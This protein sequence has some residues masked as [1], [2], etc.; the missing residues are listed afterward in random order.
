M[1]Y[2]KLDLSK[3]IPIDKSLFFK[4]TTFRKCKI[5]LKVWYPPTP[6]KNPLQLLEG[7]FLCENFLY[8]PST[9]LI[10]F[11]N[12][13]F[14]DGTTS[15]Q[16]LLPPCLPWRPDHLE[17]ISSHTPATP[18]PQKNPPPTKIDNKNPYFYLHFS[19]FHSIMRKALSFSLTPQNIFVKLALLCI[20]F[21]TVTGE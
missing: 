10:F 20:K 16:G 7:I 4:G 21:R 5:F 3:F 13:G 8:P 2:Q 15:G 19:P 9:L 11:A 18:S 12:A 1:I 14:G 17:T 6:K